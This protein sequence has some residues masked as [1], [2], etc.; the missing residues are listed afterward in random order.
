MDPSFG[1]DSPRRKVA[2]HTIAEV[3]PVSRIYIQPLTMPACQALWDL[4][5]SFAGTPNYMGFAYFWDIAFKWWLR[6]ASPAKRRRVHE[7]LRCAGLPVH[8]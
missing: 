5:C 7:A 3:G 1:R 6:D 4:D 8:G 2:L